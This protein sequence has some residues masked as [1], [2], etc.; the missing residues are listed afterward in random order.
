M[1]EINEKK[2]AAR[3]Q[4]ITFPE[5]EVEIQISGKR[6]DTIKTT[7]ET[8]TTIRCPVPEHQIVETIFYEAANELRRR[9]TQP[10]SF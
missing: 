6:Y 9:G 8:R 7:N 1:R 5:Q 3:S 2:A 4:A 10:V